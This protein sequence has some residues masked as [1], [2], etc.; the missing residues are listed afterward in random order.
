MGYASVMIS[1]QTA[2]VLGDDAQTASFLTRAWVVWSLRSPH[3]RVPGI[4]L[5]NSQRDSIGA[6]LASHIGTIVPE[7]KM[8]RS[9]Y[10]SPC[11][12]VV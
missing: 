9:A 6:V 4:S 8:N 7:P 3:F 2:P 10:G 12:I 11:A 1:R 5:R